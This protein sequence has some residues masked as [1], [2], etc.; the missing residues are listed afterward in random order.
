MSDISSIP[1]LNDLLH[2]N[3]GGRIAGQSLL[4]PNANAEKAGANASGVSA[5]N[6][7]FLANPLAGVSQMANTSAIAKDMAK[8][9]LSAT[10]VN[11]FTSSPSGGNP[12]SASANMSGFSGKVDAP[13]FREM[14]EGLIKGVHKKQMDAADKKR[15]ILLGKS[16][17]IHEA[18]LSA[19]EAGVAFNLMIQVRNKL[20]D[21]Y[22]ELLRMR[23]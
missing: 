11:A 3:S 10:N 16:D 17:N 21:S 15:D 8:S 13:G 6:A 12:E 9:G 18:M 22:T 20:V 23:V 19:Q 5:A 4:R 14:F 2:Q 7:E 1:S